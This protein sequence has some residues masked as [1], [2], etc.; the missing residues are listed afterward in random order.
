MLDV[1]SSTKNS[2]NAQNMAWKLIHTPKQ[3]NNEMYGNAW[4]KIASLAI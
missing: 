2:A 4:N 3:I 1:A